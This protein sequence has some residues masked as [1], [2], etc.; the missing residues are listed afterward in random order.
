MGTK[1][2]SRTGAEEEAKAKK[3]TGFPER[4]GCNCK[5]CLSGLACIGYVCGWKMGKVGN[6]YNSNNNANKAVPYA[7]VSRPASGASVRAAAGR[8]NFC[9]F[10]IPSCL[11]F[12]LFILIYFELIPRHR[13]TEATKTWCLEPP[14][15][16]PYF[17][18]SLPRLPRG[19]S[20]FILIFN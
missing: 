15:R 18:A 19:I 16:Q 12:F 3:P 1:L 9:Q 11:A 5:T 14:P 8:G 10:F 17:P 6:P 7:P 2:Y 13:G 4:G 20:S